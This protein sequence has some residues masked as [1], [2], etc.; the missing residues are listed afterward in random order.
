MPIFGTAG[1]IMDKAAAL[2]N[3]TEKQRYTYL[4]QFPYLEI[5][6]NDFKMIA[7]LN[8]VSVSNQRS[9]VITVPIGT[10]VISSDTIPT[11]PTD[12]V[13]IINVYENSVNSGQFYSL[14]RRN[15]LTP[16]DTQVSQFG[17]YA[18][19]NNEI[20]LPSAVG[21]IYL[22]IDY[23]STLFSLVVDENSPI[24]VINADSFLW[25]RTAGLCS[26]YIGEDTERA[27]VLDGEAGVKIDQILGIENK[28]KQG[29][30]T[31]RRPFRA[32]YKSARQ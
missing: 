30:T 5:A 26:R 29:M 28:S 14:G 13:S 3:D 23:V 15:F 21:P 17:V 12:L 7:Q 20:Q 31:R 1:D 27:G 18:W 8:G 10:T 2:C 24:K 6:L 32:S 11:L 9:A 16:T 19:N 22:K 25:Y 4:A